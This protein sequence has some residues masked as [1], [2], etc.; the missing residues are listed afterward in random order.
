M[1]TTT[2]DTPTITALGKEHLRPQAPLSTA[3]WAKRY[4]WVTQGP[5]IGP[6]GAPSPWNADLFPIQQYVMDAIDDPHWMRTVV[7]APPQA[8]GKTDC[9]AINPI[10]KRLDYDK[11]DA[12]YV[13]ASRD[14]ANDQW[15]KKFK[16]SLDEM[17]AREPDP[18]KQLIPTNRDEIGKNVR[19]DFSNATSLY[20]AGAESIG[21]LSAS[22]IPIIV[23][24]DCQAIIN[25]FPIGHPVDIAFAR[26]K[27]LPDDM[28]TLVMLGTVST[29]NA[30]HWRAL[31]RST[32]WRPY[33][34]C[35][36]C[37]AYQL[38][39][40][41][42]MQFDPEDPDRAGECFIRCVNDGCKHQ[43]RFDD[44]PAMLAE[45][46]MVAR[47]QTIDRKGRVRGDLPKT[48][49]A[50]F[51]WNALY[52]PVV[53]WATHVV[54][55][56]DS[57]GDP[58]AEKLFGIDVEVR[59]HKDPDPDESA[60]TI[61][62]LAEHVTQSYKRG[63]VPADAD[64]VTVTG[65]VHDHFIYYIVRA[66]HR[67]TGTSWL[68]DAGNLGVHGPKKDELLTERERDAR[69]GF[70][71]R[72]ALEEVW[73][74][75]VRGWPV[76]AAGG[77]IAEVRRAEL[78]LFDGRWR[79]DAVYQA[80]VRFN[81]TRGCTWHMILGES[82]RRG[83]PIW[84]RKPVRGKR[85]QVHRPVNVDEAKHVL[86]ELLAIPTDQPGAW[87]TYDDDTLEAY[88]RHMISEHYVPRSDKPEADKDDK[89]WKKRSGH[90]NHWW[91]CEVYQVAC[92]IA[93]GVR[94]PTREQEITPEVVTDWFKRQREARK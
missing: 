67:E 1:T 52:W 4:R 13:S 93:C 30:Y 68:V 42:R 59:P 82:G 63:S 73:Q 21:N 75:E 35:L 31:Q 79:G 86:R 85:G 3:E 38:L 26:S 37:E 18:D 33:L 70:A 60:L 32:Y 65:D 46:R 72:K 50:G 47:T 92:A 69:I 64:V 62:M 39:E 90:A 5:M 8:G 80:V 20:F 12:I 94:L 91:D 57:R 44:L 81:T 28:R 16:P 9:A 66:W 6:S 10:L 48:R 29:E 45:L 56:I 74:M 14:K 24:D 27:S 49:M 7:V 17:D 77:E 25:E 76:V 34:P 88:H 61:E 23:V 22:T 40:W 84:P 19:R 78:G 36:S 83:I 2:A 41:Y 55:W 89:I 43:I 51:W 54:E 53:D 58:D 87:H 15:I 11:Q 71:I